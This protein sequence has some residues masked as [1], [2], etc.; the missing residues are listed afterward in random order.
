MDK[1]LIGEGSN[2]KIML[3]R[4]FDNPEKVYAAKQLKLNE[5]KIDHVLE[6]VKMHRI[7]SHKNII[8]FVDFVE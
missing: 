7:L 4:E 6:E 3:I 5:N 8:G 1:E 2:G